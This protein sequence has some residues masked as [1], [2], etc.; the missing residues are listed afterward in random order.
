MLQKPSHVND[1]DHI[2]GS[3][4]IGA[5]HQSFDPTKKGGHTS[6]NHHDG[7]LPDRNTGD[8]SHLSGF[9]VSN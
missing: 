6:R 3:K 4:N 9:S 5:R 2:N 8:P 1:F 7:L